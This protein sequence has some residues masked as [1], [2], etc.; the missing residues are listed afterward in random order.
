MKHYESLMK[1]TLLS[2]YRIHLKQIKDIIH[3]ILN[4]ELKVTDGVKSYRLKNKAL[5]FNR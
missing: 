4:M 1:L 5:I 2:F 3:T